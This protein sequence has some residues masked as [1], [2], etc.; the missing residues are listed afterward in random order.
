MQDV[1]R[2]AEG[3]IVQLTKDDDPETRGF[4]FKIDFAEKWYTFLKRRLIKYQKDSG[5]LVMDAMK[6]ERKFYSM[7]I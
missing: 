6:D 7:G 3:A 2:I 1:V 5:L 4:P